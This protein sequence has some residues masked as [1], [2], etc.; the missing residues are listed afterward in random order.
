VGTAHSLLCRSERVGA[1]VSNLVLF[2]FAVGMAVVVTQKTRQWAYVMGEVP[3][4]TGCYLCACCLSYLRSGK[5][6]RVESENDTVC[7]NADTDSEGDTCITVA[8]TDGAGGLTA[9]H[10]KN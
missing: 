1:V 5:L 4:S 7:S 3:P 8:N 6:A 2:I 10:S 9:R